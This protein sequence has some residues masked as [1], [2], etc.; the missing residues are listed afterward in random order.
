MPMIRVSTSFK[1]FLDKM[2]R[3]YVER[4]GDDNITFEFVLRAEIGLEDNPKQK[5]KLLY[6]DWF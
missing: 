6:P 2:K 5:K 1:R 4:T 3:E